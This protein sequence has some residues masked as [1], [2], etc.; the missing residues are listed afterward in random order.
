MLPALAG[1]SAPPDEGQQRGQEVGGEARGHSPQGKAGCPLD[2]LIGHLQEAREDSL[3]AKGQGREV[4]SAPNFPQGEEGQ[5]EL[6]GEGGDLGG[7]G[8]AL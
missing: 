7:M 3:Q 2:L 4:H 5:L 6:E 1:V 8:E